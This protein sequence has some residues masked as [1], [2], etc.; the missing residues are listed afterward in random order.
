MIKKFFSNM[1]TAQKVFVFIPIVFI[2]SMLVS[3]GYIPEFPDGI[4]RFIYYL[5]RGLGME[6]ES[7]G[8]FGSFGGNP[9]AGAA[10]TAGFSII[11]SC[12]I[13]FFLFKTKNK[14]KD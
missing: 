3:D 7:R 14:T 9:Q 11:I 8:G 2:V 6:L 12:I 1:N 4:G 10:D 5:G 13:G